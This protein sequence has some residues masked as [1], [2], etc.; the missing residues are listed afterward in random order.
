[1]NSQPAPITQELV[2]AGGGHSHVLVLRMLAMNPPPNCRITLISKQRRAPYSGMLPG[3]IAGCYSQDDFHIDLQKLAD[4]ASVRLI[5]AD[6]IGLDT[7]RQQ[8]LCRDRPPVRYDLLSI[9]TGSTPNLS[10]AEGAREHALPIKPLDQFLPQWHA[11]EQQMA[12]VGDTFS[13]A[14]V[15]AGA[16]GT[17]VA[18]AIKSRLSDLI[19]AN[20]RTCQLSVHLF[21][22]SSGILPGHGSRVQ[23]RMLATLKS[24]DIQVHQQRVDKIS[25]S[26][27][28][29]ADGNQWPVDKVV[30]TTRATAAFWIADSTLETDADGFIAVDATLQSRSHPNVFAAGDVASVIAHPRPKSGVFAVRQGAPLTENLKRFLANQSLKPFKPQQHFLSILYL[31]K[32]TALASW[33]GLAWQGNWVWRWK[34]WIDQR[35]MATLHHYPNQPKLLPGA[36][37][38]ALENSAMRCGGCGAKIGASLL[39][40]VLQSLPIITTD[41]V[42][43]GVDGAD[44]GAVIEVPKGKLLIQSVDHFR[45][46]IDDPYLLGRIA[47]EHALSDCYAMG[48]QPHSALVTATVPF[49][50]PAIVKATLQTLMT[51]AVE[52]L[53]NAGASLVGGHSAEG[54]EL[55]LGAT[56][57]GLAESAQ[58][59]KKNAL[60]VGDQLLLTKAIGT[61][62]IFA[63]AG[64]SLAKGEWVESAL[65][66]MLHSNRGAS[67]SA[68]Q[69][70]VVAATDITG[71]GLAGHLLEMAQASSCSIELEL[72]AIPYLPGAVELSKMGIRSTLFPQNSEIKTS[73]LLLQPTLDSAKVDLLFDPQTSGGLVLAIGAEKIESLMT[74]L[75]R[76]G[77]SAWL[78]GQIITREKGQLPLVIN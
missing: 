58:L 47:T 10:T 3:F 27:L 67:E 52:T 20:Q 26:Q 57:N 2:L 35:F 66:S 22:G 51:G 11:I 12:H 36:S 30:W 8:V 74:E 72:N 65:S 43:S 63:A 31:G 48:A 4:Y 16:G 32:G 76:R 69:M 64:Y 68:Q 70:G 29:T 23:R 7:E 37:S 34:D 42:I 53:N 54:A 60:Q 56:I 15:G 77:E 25:A 18:L 5:C 14:V 61:G 44:D 28:T 40:G 50:A 78:I 41:G 13:I 45:A 46:F 62:V 39:Q 59:M 17:E 1:M 71:F 33:R 9:N 24:R 21:A 19:A 55:A 75:Q 49:A 38:L 73:S 6:V